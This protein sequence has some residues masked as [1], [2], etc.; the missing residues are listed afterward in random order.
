MASKAKRTTTKE[1]TWLR[2]EVIIRD[3]YEC[4]NR[5][6]NAKGGPRGDTRLEAHHIVRPSDG[7]GDCKD[8]LETLCADCHRK[9][10]SYGD[11]LTRTPRGRTYSREMVINAFERGEKVDAAEIANRIGCSPGTARRRLKEARENGDVVEH[12]NV[13]DGPKGRDILKGS[14]L[15]SLEKCPMEYARED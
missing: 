5:G 11:A 6:C 9:T 3:N 8:N 15:W 1:W 4:Q 13:I 12:R 10:P 7:G 14:V 2:R